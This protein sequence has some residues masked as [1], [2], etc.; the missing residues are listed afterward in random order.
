MSSVGRD[1][2]ELDKQPSTHAPWRQGGGSECGW[3]AAD[4]RRN[5][6]NGCS[7]LPNEARELHLPIK[8]RGTDA[9]FAAPDVELPRTR[10]DNA[11]NFVKLVSTVPD[12]V[13]GLSPVS[14]RAL[15]VQ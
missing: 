15:K 1:L 14:R 10:P 6:G 12:D 2:R 3:L 7:V 5:V 8:N 9:K 13:V 11:L 4:G